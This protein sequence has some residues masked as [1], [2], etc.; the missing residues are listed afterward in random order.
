MIDFKTALYD[1][2][3]H[4]AAFTCVLLAAFCIMGKLGYGVYVENH[5]CNWIAS[6]AIIVWA[7][8]SGAVI[9][10]KFPHLFYPGE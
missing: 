5:T 2:I 3:C 9:R 4:S 1:Q 7:I 10:Y 8:V 6:G